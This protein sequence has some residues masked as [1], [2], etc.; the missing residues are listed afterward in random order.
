MV[1]GSPPTQPPSVPWADRGDAVRGPVQDP[2]RSARD[3]EILRSLARRIPAKDAGAHNNLGVVFYNKGLHE[4]AIE[5]FEQAL[6]LDPRME[7]AERNLQICYLGTGYLQRLSTRLQQRLAVNPDDEHAREA[8]AR[9]CFN[10]GDHAG[11]VRELRHLL[12][13]RS[14]DARIYQRLARAELKR[15]NTDEALAALRQAEAFAPADGRVKFLIG[16]LLY[17]RGLA[18]DARELLEQAIQLEPLLAEAH[19]VLAFVYGDLDRPDDAQRASACAAQL[20]P[21]FARAEAGLSLDGYSTARYQELIGSAGQHVPMV[22]EGGGLAH[23]SLGLAFRQKALYDEALREFRLATER[24]ADTFLVQQAQAE[25]LLLRGHSDEALRLYERLVEEESASPKLWN[26]IGVAH[27]QTGSLDAAEEAYRHALQLDAAYALAWNNLAVVQHHRGAAEAEAAFRSALRE[28]RPLADVWRNLA[29]ML[30]HAGRPDESLAA[31]QQALHLDPDSASVA[32]AMG[33]LL[34]K[35]GQPHEARALLLRAVES[36][37]GLAEARYH[38]AFALST[39]GD[40]QGALRETKI[41]LE[42][43]PYIPTPRFRLLIDLQFEEASIL[44]PELDAAE[45]IRGEDVVRSFDFEP[46]ALESVFTA[47]PAG[48]RTSSVAQEDLLQAQQAL[49]HGLLEQATAA[50]QRAAVTGAD[51][52]EVL[53][54]LG[55]IFLRRELAGEAVERFNDALAEIRRGAAAD[56]DAA[57]RRALHGAARS[58]LD[59]GRMGEAVEA[60]ERLCSLAPT[61]VEA[62]RTFGEALSRVRD[63]ARAAIVLEQARLIAPDD[64]NLLTQLGTAYASAGDPDGAEYA[65]RRAITLDEFAVGARCALADVLVQEGRAAEAEAEY[66]R[67]LETLPTYGAAAFGLADLEQGRGRTDSALNV[68]IE[69]LIRDPYRTDALLRLGDL[70]LQAGRARE[71]RF[72]YDRVLRF[73]PGSVAASAGLAQIESAGA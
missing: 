31:F 61:D 35:L 42:L 2:P 71:A 18:A 58:L 63:Y 33:I 10:S 24:G 13:L 64:I 19:H 15:G 73:E 41:A 9:A 22:A 23:Y 38:L 68:L 8:L 12:R 59:L 17:Q 53:L 32:A 51:R 7:V 44:A 20:N 48:L 16:E 65:L 28:G 25:M 66:R 60:A 67:A 1:D 50:A 14:R 55:E 27:H 49:E 70:L 46:A 37:P 34:L 47:A 36:E 45:R 72:A 3:L 39:L 62:L 52:A 54:L 29:L 6:E 56:P 4:E 43:N 11:A 26:E 69:L 5:E 57:L 30:Q 21:S 40:H